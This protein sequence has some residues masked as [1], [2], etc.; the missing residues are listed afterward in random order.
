MSFDFSKLESKQETAKVP[1]YKPEE[2][3]EPTEG[4]V[5]DLAEV[6][7][8]HGVYLLTDFYLD[9]APY[10]VSGLNELG[11]QVIIPKKD[12]IDIIER[13]KGFKVKY[14]MFGGL[15]GWIIKVFF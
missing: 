14:S 2:L 3:E 1:E 10:F 9:Y 5:L 15:L 4:A 7:T 12:L 6:Q 11:F 13:P 8:I